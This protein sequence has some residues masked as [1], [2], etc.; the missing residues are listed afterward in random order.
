MWDPGWTLVSCGEKLCNLYSPWMTLT[1]GPTIIKCSFDYH[2]KNW[3]NFKFGEAESTCPSS[4]QNV[5]S[6]LT[7]YINHIHNHT[8]TIH[9]SLEL[10]S[11]RWSIQ[12]QTLIVLIIATSA[13]LLWQKEASDKS[14][15]SCKRENCVCHFNWRQWGIM[16]SYLT[17]HLTGWVLIHTI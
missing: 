2:S 11:G 10:T 1:E 16:M 13:A 9:S 6:M 7:L 4:T 8:Q 12:L 3:R 15:I 17:Y 14:D 5:L